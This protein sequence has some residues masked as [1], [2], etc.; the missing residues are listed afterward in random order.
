M[1]NE[2]RKV[3]AMQLFLMWRN[4]AIGLASLVVVMA[5]SSILPPYLSPLVSLLC[6]AG[7][8]TL[9]YN[10]KA[11]MGGACVL[12]MYSLFV[13]LIAYS[14]V[15][16]LICLLES[17][18]VINLP[19]TMLV[20]GMFIPILFI[21]PTCFVTILAVYLL[22]SRLRIC[23]DCR[24]NYG[25][26]YERGRVGAVHENET[27]FQMKNILG[28]LGILSVITWAYYLFLFVDINLNERDSYIFTW[29]SVIFVIADEIYFI[30]RYYN[31]YLDLREQ[32]DIL[33]PAEIDEMGDNVFVRYYVVCK[34]DTYLDP[35]TQDL[36][37]SE[38]TVIDTPFFVKLPKFNNNISDIKRTI[39]K[40]TG[41]SG[42]ELRFFFSRTS[43]FNNNRQ[44]ARYFYFLDGSP[45][46]YDIKATGEWIPF[47]TCKEIYMKN[48]S[49]LASIYVSDLTRLATIMLTE[50]IFDERGFRKLRL[51]N[52]KPTFS[53]EDVRKSKLDFQDDKWLKVSLFNSD[54]KFFRLRR[55]FRRMGGSR[56]RFDSWT[57]PLI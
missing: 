25:D 17:W 54:D 14:F 39:E 47:R 44:I 57:T 31:F 21:A 18:K 13:S 32:D 1:I 29:L 52:Y 30:Y 5:I 9:I 8:Y 40:L 6:A 20:R 24:L 55:L 49:S 15:I 41:V 42:G 53:L 37:N 27:S 23:I 26:S 22:R 34:N 28:L 35:N 11:K 50:K 56:D 10:T 33:T 12:V 48:P 36:I 38:K 4:L 51:R 16:L 43:Q 7:I 45:E 46:D 19:P 2:I 3:S